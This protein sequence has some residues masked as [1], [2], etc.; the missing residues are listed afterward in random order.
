MRYDPVASDP[1]QIEPGKCFS[2]GE[3]AAAM[4][5]HGT[6]GQIDVCP[7]CATSVLPKLIAD[8]VFV[9]PDLSKGTT[10]YAEQLVKVEASFWAAVASRVALEKRR[11]AEHC[12]SVMGERDRL[13]D[14]LELAGAGPGT[15]DGLLV[16]E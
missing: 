7:G 5:W 12:A 1:D 11:L 3:R 16:P 15:V 2:C 13:L 14:R 8:A 6:E 9:P 4:M 10:G